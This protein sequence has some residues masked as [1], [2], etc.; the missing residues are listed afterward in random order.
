MAPKQA[1]RFSPGASGQAT[2]AGKPGAVGWPGRAVRLA[3]EASNQ[4]NC[5]V[6]QGPH[7]HG[8]RSPRAVKS[9]TDSQTLASDAGPI[10][11]PFSMG[12]HS[13]PCS[14]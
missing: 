13:F 12:S 10:Q 7:R 11:G 9:V 14:G 1:L 2:A 3:E 6:S 8:D 5:P 4:L